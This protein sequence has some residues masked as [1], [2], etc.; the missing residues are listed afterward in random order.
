M[1]LNQILTFLA[2][3]G[4]PKQHLISDAEKNYTFRRSLFITL[5]LDSYAHIQK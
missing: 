3:P 4:S 2:Q 5:V 1:I